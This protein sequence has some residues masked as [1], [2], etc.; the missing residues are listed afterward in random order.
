[1]KKLILIIVAISTFLVLPAVR[2]MAQDRATARVSAM[3]IIPLTA[4]EYTS[5]N[6]GRVFPGS[7]GGTITVSPTGYVVTSSTVVADASPR[8]PG[9]F[10]VTGQTDATFSIALPDGP[11][12]L[13]STDDSKTMVVSDWVTVPENG[14]AGIKLTG[15]NQ[16]VMVGAT[17]NVGSLDENPKGIYTGSYQITF[18]YN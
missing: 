9:G 6:F 12:T 13:T 16:M 10:Y 4:T 11:A 2:V 1:M 7:Q 8:N 3:I 5:L 15:G 18:A 17:L 14:D